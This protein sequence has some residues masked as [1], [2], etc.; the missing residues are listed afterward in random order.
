MERSSGF[1]RPALPSSTGDEE[2]QVSLND[3]R[4]THAPTTPTER[5]KVFMAKGRR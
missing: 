5:T 2:S 3:E 1:S 4:H